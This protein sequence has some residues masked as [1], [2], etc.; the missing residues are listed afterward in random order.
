MTRRAKGVALII[1]GILLCAFVIVVLHVQWGSPLIHWLTA[2]H[3]LLL[4]F[5]VDPDVRVLSLCALGAVISGVLFL[6]SNS[7]KT[8][9]VGWQLVRFLLH[10]AAVY[11]IAQ[12]VAQLAGWTRLFLLPLLQLPTSSSSFQF[13]FSHIFVFSFV[14]ALFA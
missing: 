8:V 2:I 5:G 4:S 11:A 13:L 3:G 6:N 9:T 1:L 12:Y 7:S 10:L 14:P